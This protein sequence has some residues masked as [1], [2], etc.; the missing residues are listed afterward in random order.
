MENKPIPDT[1]DNPVTWALYRVAL[2][3]AWLCNRLGISANLVSGVSLIAAVLG[4]ICLVGLQSQFWFVLLWT[5]SIVL[6]FADGT[7]ARMSGRANQ[8]AFRLDHTLDL[9]KITAG[10]VGVTAYWNTAQLWVIGML[11]LASAL[12]FTVLNH[13]LSC[14]SGSV[15][16]SKTVRH[17]TGS[18]PYRRLLEPLFTLHAGSLLLLALACLSCELAYAVLSY[19]LLLCAALAV[20]VARRLRNL[21]KPSDTAESV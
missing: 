14:A 1:G 7:V 18:R 6:D 5:I 3:L 8:T 9:V 16:S 15:A 13:D 10:L 21:P 20:R 4:A 2:P 19:L 12:I 11:T 17:P